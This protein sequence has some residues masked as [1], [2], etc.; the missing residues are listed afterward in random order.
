MEVTGLCVDSDIL[1][2]YLRGKEATRA[3][4]LAANENQTLYI[5][6]VNVVEIYSGKETKDPRR[7]ALIDEFMASFQIIE[8]SPLIA[9]SAGALR[10][11]YQVPFGDAIV[12][13][14][15]IAYKLKLVTRNIKHYREIR[16]LTLF[17]PY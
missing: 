1:I 14:S 11:D 15:A 10:R 13:A 17:T 5:S 16:N 12:A 2:D 7:K 8:L 9:Q 4:L 3:F 6:I